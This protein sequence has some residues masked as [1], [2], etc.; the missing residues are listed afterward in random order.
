MAMQNDKLIGS[1]ISIITKAKV[2][3][4][5]VLI[6]TDRKERSMKLENV[7]SYGSEG[8]RD[9]QGEVP[10]KDERIASVVF[11]VDHI[12]NFEIIKPRESPKPPEIQDPAIIQ[13]SGQSRTAPR[14]ET[15][16]F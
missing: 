9:G 3:Y 4:E 15:K 2:R 14:A 12:E 7:K 10:E 1:T 5:G 16:P 8:R 13:E 11:K 6:Q